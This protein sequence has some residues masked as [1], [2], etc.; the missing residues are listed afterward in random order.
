MFRKVLTTYF[1]VQVRWSH[2]DVLVF[3]S[4]RGSSIV[5]KENNIQPEYAKEILSNLGISM[6]D[7]ERGRKASMN[8]TS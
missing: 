2:S 5:K 7:F 6:D 1:D 8:D 3:Y 4:S